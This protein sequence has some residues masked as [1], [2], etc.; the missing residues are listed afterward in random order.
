M[1]LFPF[2]SFFL[3]YMTVNQAIAQMLEAEEDIKKENGA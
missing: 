3:R 2:I 1:P